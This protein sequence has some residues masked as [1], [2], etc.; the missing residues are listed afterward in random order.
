MQTFRHIDLKDRHTLA[1][2]AIADTLI[3]LEEVKEVE[4]TTQDDHILG[5]GSNT[6]F[7]G[8]IKKRIICPKFQGIEIISE[9]TETVDVKSLAGTPWHELVSYTVSENLYG[10]ENLAL[11]PGTVGAAPVQ[12]IGAYGRECADTLLEISAYDRIEKRHVQ[13]KRADC[14]FGYRSSRFKHD[15]KGRYLITAITFR[16]SKK[17]ILHT[18]YPGIGE[19]IETPLQLFKRICEIRRS[20]LPN[21]DSCPNAGSFFHNP[22]ISIEQLRQLK[23]DHAEIPSFFASEGKVKIPAAWLIEQSGFKGKYSKGVGM[24]EKHALVLINRGGNGADILQ[25]ADAVRETVKNRFQISL[26]IEPTIVGDVCVN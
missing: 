2:T 9:N 15:W 17:G 25:Y 16:L 1:A 23:A 21:P 8:D 24:Y 20:K 13:L 19:E 14:Q 6:V 12:N 3:E 7:V 26:T 22:I 10:L 11:I 4:K 18:G 5:G